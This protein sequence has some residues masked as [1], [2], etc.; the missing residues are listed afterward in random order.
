MRG[1]RSPSLVESGPRVPAVAADNALAKRSTISPEAVGDYQHV[2]VDL[3][4]MERDPERWQLGQGLADAVVV[5]TV[6]DLTV[7]YERLRREGATITIPLRR[8]PWGELMMQLTD[9]NGVAIQLTE[10]ISPIT[11]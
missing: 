9:P 10:W 2:A 3:V 5:F 8:E 11:S 7:E 6:T 1:P 4:L